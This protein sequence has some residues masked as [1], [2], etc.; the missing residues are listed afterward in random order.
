M[1]NKSQAKQIT[2]TAAGTP[3]GALLR[4]Y[5]QPIALNEEL[6]GPRPVRPARVMGQD[7]VLFRDPDGKLGLLDRDC[8]HRGADLAFG[9]HEVWPALNSFFA[10]RAGE[11][12]QTRSV[13]EFARTLRA[14][15]NARRL[16]SA[17]A[18]L[19]AGLGVERTLAK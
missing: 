8:P 1:M 6:N 15:A 12:A 19:G 17:A 3:A 9:R 2:E 14:P 11:P 4:R 16:L 18:Q 10:D 5:W 7:L 13:A